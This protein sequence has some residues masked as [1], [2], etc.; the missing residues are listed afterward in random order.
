MKAVPKMTPQ[1]RTDR[2]DQRRRADE[3]LVASYIHELS[4]RHRAK[5]ESRRAEPVPAPAPC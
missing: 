5:A 4:T 1:R 2:P 3:A